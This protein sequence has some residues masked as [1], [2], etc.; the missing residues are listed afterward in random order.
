MADFEE[1]DDF[2]D[3]TLEAMFADEE[4]KI[5]FFIFFKLTRWLAKLQ[6]SEGSLLKY[7]HGD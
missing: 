4:G 3:V 2:D 5:T 7:M 1:F 6:N